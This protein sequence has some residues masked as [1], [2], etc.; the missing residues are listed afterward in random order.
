MRAILLA[1]LLALAALPAHRAAAGEMAV[2][3]MRSEALGRT[4]NFSVYEPDGYGDGRHYP[5][6]YFLPGISRRRGEWV[7]LAL[8]SL[9]DAAIAEGRMPPA[10]IV[11]PELGASWGVDRKEHMQTALMRDLLPEIGRRWRVLP[12]R[13]GRA[14]V[15]VSAGGFA[16]LRLALLHPEHFAAVAVMSPA[17]YV[18]E[19]PANS[20]A[21]GGGVFA[22]DTLPEHW[23]DPAIWQSLNYPALLPGFRATGISMPLFIASGDA[24]IL[25]THVQARRLF[26]V[27]QTMRMPATLRLVPGGHTY[28]VWRE[29]VPDALGFALRFTGVA[30]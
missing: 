14:L 9:A 3:A 26:D 17:V 20:A 21:R 15:G 24:D 4:W 11:V 29:L 10:L 30:E 12:G 13:Q 27:W 23:F 8:P 16:G 6:V 2:H 22:G 18:P 25:G 1:V 7:A 28:G 19:P 5:V